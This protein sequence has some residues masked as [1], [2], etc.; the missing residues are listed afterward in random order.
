MALERKDNIG[1]TTTSIGTGTINLDAVAQTGAR[2]F[3]GNVTTGST[4][5]YDIRLADGSEWEVGEGVFTD[6]APDTLTRVTVYASS[7][8]G[9]LVNFSA[10]TKNVSLVFT[11]GENT[12]TPASAS[13]PASLDFAEDTDN[14]TNKI[15]I[16]A[17]SAIASDKVLTLPDATDT[18]VG[19]ATTDTLTNKT[20]TA[21]VLN[22]ALS[23]DAKATG[24]TINAGTADD[25]FVTSK[26]IADSTVMRTPM[27]YG[28][29]V[30][31]TNASGDAS[32]AYSTAF[33]TSTSSV[34]VSNGDHGIGNLAIAINGSPSASVFN[35]NVKI[36]DT[37]AVYVGT[38]RVNYV[39][40]GV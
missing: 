4:V 23:G 35:I 32:I 9:A 6:G 20:L 3:A 11:A 2:I 31:T 1:D 25:D 14:G 5:H 16:T 19:K 22:G 38:C 12:F 15:T 18:L 37:A 39:A 8:A 24:T 30:V 13:A 28:S 10:G 17:P 27:R 33:G 26:A 29:A 40:F 21:P 7:N 36:A 34:I